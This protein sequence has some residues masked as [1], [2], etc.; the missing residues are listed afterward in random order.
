MLTGLG[1]TSPIHLFQIA[2]DSK[3][4]EGSTIGFDNDESLEGPFTRKA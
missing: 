3:K 2:I 4:I 1:P